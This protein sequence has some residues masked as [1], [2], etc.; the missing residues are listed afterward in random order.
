MSLFMYKK[1]SLVISFMKIEKIQT[2][3]DLFLRLLLM[4]SCHLIGSQNRQSGKKFNNILS[5]ALVNVDT[6][7][8]FLVWRY[9]SRT[10]AEDMHQRA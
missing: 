5:F 1:I 8:M 7:D 2:V 10:L 6:A 4:L 9:L 3:T